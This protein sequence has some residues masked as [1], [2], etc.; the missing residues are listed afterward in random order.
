M[1][2]LSYANGLVFCYDFGTRG[3]LSLNVQNIIHAT[4]HSYLHESN[5]FILMQNMKRKRLQLNETLPLYIQ[6]KNKTE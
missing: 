2:F 4:A 1:G 5:V 6:I 3:L